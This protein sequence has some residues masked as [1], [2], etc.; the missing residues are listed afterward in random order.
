MP[1]SKYINVTI[2]KQPIDLGNIEELP[3]SISYVVRDRDNFQDIKSSTA[4]SITFP[5]TVNND[6]V[7]NTMH[8]PGV[9][10]LTSGQAFKGNRPAVIE[11]N[12]QELLVGK[13]LL[14]AASHT[15]VPTKYEYDFYGNNGDWI[16]DLKETTLYDLLNDI[17]FTFTKDLIISSWNFDGMNK[18]L[19]YVFA[20]VRY[21]EPMST[22]QTISG[23]VVVNEIEDYNML[24]EYM[25]P[26]LS[27]YW[28]LYRAFKSLGY[29]I[30][31]DFLDTSYFR[32]Q[33]MPW[34]WGSFLNAD[35][36]QLDNLDFL[37]KGIGEVSKEDEG[38]TGFWD[39]N[40]IN[41]SVNGAFDN[42]G[43]YEYDAGAFEMKWTYP[44]AS[45]FNYGTLDATFHFEAFVQAVATANS[46]VELR[47]QWF[48][49]G[50]KVGHGSDNGNGTLLVNLN[51]PAI[52]RREFA[53]Q[54]DDWATFT[55]VPGD[56][57]SAKIYLHT[58]KSNAGI[59]HIHATVQAFEL[60]FFRIPLGG[61][62]NFSNYTG[63]KKYK[64]LDFFA[65]I[66]D[67]FNLVIQTDPVNKVVYMEPQHPYSLVDDQS[68][69]TGGYYN[70]HYIDWSE[71]QDL[72][73][74]S[75]VEL[76]SDADREIRMAYKDDSN[77]GTLKTVQDRN[78]NRLAMAKY[79]LPDRFKVNPNDDKTKPTIE[80][81]FFSP[82]MHMDVV[83]WK[84]LTGDPSIMP[85]MPVLIPENISN[86]S[87]G[88]AQNTFEPKTAYYKG[89][90]AGWGWV[91]DGEVRNGFP[92]MFAVN[93][94]EGGQDDPI[95]SYADE[96]ITY[97]DDGT[98]KTAG[99]GHLRRFYLQRFANIA[100]GQYYKTFVHL[101]NND[102]ANQL[103]REHKILRGQKW[104]LAQINNY[105]PLKEESTEIHLIKWAPVEHA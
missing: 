74:E 97:N 75:D 13:A 80:N 36:T 105:K 19:P 55:V 99:K 6:K 48:K 18:D 11:A 41:D 7:G 68:T 60:D 57:I 30:Q 95:L 104:E 38:Y 82:L 100:N 58:F 103:H 96:V 64:F 61:T 28:L 84:G 89:I 43:V 90:Q 1:L 32:R 31:S 69:K 49:N 50:V 85:Q 53:D 86:T 79:V 40:V 14:K 56:V 10:D 22:F 15:N 9:E 93:Y 71:K 4:L 42:Q 72:S 12:G 66:V 88:E 29:R 91:F 25:K 76:F 63:F 39:L 92:Y 65:G 44:T 101:N 47:I 46:D 102:V 54:I 67:E 20:P 87:A 34:T 83:Q 94:R 2:D 98:P 37:A 8:N 16:I 5:A 81:R 24:P 23:G 73:K 45:Q 62:I 59:S 27:K 33:V 3:L 78:I 70:G 17:T 51:A 35:G 52:G 26:S 21:G 77:D